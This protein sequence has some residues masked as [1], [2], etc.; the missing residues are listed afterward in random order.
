[1]RRIHVDW[2]DDR[3]FA[4]RDARPVRF[5]AVSDE[6]DPALEHA[7]NRDALGPIDGIIGCGD[8]EATWLGF[9]SD[10]FAAPLVYVRGNHDRGRA[11]EPEVSGATGAPRGGG[12][13]K[14][15][16]SVAPAA[17][18]SGQ[19]DRLAGIAI[20]GL[21]WPG[22]DLPGNRRRP[23]LAWRPAISSAP[24]PV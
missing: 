11:L 1:I 4:E 3:P 12:A 22:V 7:V 13:W 9:L 15:E 2:P 16:S 8:L 20:A 5:L 14:Q 6:E 21:E 10:A 23:W 18:G 17:L 24:R 19:I